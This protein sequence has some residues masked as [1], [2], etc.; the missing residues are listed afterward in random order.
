MDYFFKFKT[1]GRAT[2]VHEYKR[3]FIKRG[4]TELDIWFNNECIRRR[5]KPNY[6]S[7]YT[8][9]T[10]SSATKALKTATTV[11]VKEEVKKHYFKLNLLDLKLKFLYFKITSVLH[12]LEW[13]SL[14][15]SLLSSL[16][17][18]KE[19]KLSRLK[20]KI[21]TLTSHQNQHSYNYTHPKK[22]TKQNTNNN[23]LFNSTAV[24]STLNTS[25]KNISFDNSIFKSEFIDSD[26]NTNSFSDFKFHNRTLN[27]SQTEFDHNE[28]EVLNLGLKYN[29][30]N[31]PTIEDL[32]VIAVECE[33]CISFSQNTQLKETLRSQTSTCLNNFYKNINNSDQ[34][35]TPYK[36]TLTSIKHKIKSNDLVISKA[37]K[38]NCLV[39]LDKPEYI[40]KVNQ[41]LSS[42]DF[43]QITTN[44]LDRFMTKLKNTLKLTH[45]TL[46]LFNTNKFK[47]TPINPLTPFLYGLPKIHKPEV[48]IRPVVSYC[49][50][51]CHKL[52]IWLNHLL[53][54][55]TNFNSPFSVKNSTQLSQ[56][57]K[58]LQ[59]PNTAILVSFD[60]TNLFPS[61]PT[62][63]CTLL[64]RNLLLE[65]ADLPQP[66]INNICSLVDL[67]LD[68]NFFIFNNKFYKQNSGLA[69]GSA[70]SP[71]LAELF[72][73]NLEF[74][75]MNSPLFS[76]IITIKRYVDDIFAVF[77]GSHED[78]NNFI[79]F[80]NSLHPSI[81]FTHES[82]NNFSLPF[83]DLKISRSLNN[84]KFA[85]FHKPTSTDSIIPYSSNHPYSQK[86][87]T[88]HSYFSRLFSIPLDYSDFRT[89][90][91]IIRQIGSNNGYPQ[92]LI[93][94][95]YLKHLNKH[96]NKK[97]IHKPPQNKFC[98]SLS[99]WGPLSHRIKNIF[100]SFN[101]ETSFKTIHSLKSH[102]GNS[103]E[104]VSPLDKSGVYRVVCSSENCNTAYV[105]QTGRKFSIR[106]NEHLK[107][108][109]RAKRLNLSPSKIKSNFSRH[110][111][112]NNHEF[113][114]DNDTT[115]LH[116]CN[117]SNKLD[118][119]EIMEIN[120]MSKN[121][122]F[123][124][125]NDQ[126]NHSSTHFFNALLF[127]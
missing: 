45:E 47:L 50:S 37:D 28:Q 32:E 31:S 119:L 4:L 30:H 8:N 46:T 18:Q 26:I 61:I 125:V 10:S 98:Y 87:A 69:M 68:Q 20:N 6:V 3:C 72:M 107:E 73:S 65:T 118:L 23:D 106:I 62:N 36:K 112:T 78:L 41:F 49:N 120:K 116:F 63:E 95:I 27:L 101:I 16:Y 123:H 11:W 115:L 124:S 44:P 97:L 99:F 56:E 85:I 110:I 14:S 9:N 108:I 83:L 58:D 22:I 15:D 55:L 1:A 89:E 94:K 77:D 111:V 39:V 84:L 60:V 25:I 127:K 17:F 100:Q 80:L 19:I 70:L 74:K 104:K 48:P 5:L 42:E 96:L 86:L 75:I 53:L 117:K 126:I 66:H 13:D 79:T 51:P 103:K 88:F 21:D 2:L 82:E 105:G 57:L 90:L 33:N 7:L 71:L 43:T 76:H 59:I 91:N 113:N 24:S 29:F 109:E 52:S 122:S 54:S 64:V 114:P 92:V 12:P 81:N 93:N 38:G 34:R 67:V 102:I 40:N 121:P 35:P